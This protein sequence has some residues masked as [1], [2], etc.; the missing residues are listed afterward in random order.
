MTRASEPEVG[1]SQ[2]TSSPLSV[3]ASR[4]LASLLFNYNINNL[5]SQPNTD[6]TLQPS[7]LSPQ[8]LSQSPYHGPRRHRLALVVL[9]LNRLRV[10]PL[11]L[12]P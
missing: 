4:C 6:L 12:H 2:Q 7:H 3:L 8:T 11:L 9:L 1:S 5:S 10:F